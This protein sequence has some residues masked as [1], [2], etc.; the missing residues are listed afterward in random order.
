MFLLRNRIKTSPSS[1]VHEEVKK[2]QLQEHNVENNF[3]ANPWTLFYE[4]KL[5]CHTAGIKLLNI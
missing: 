1:N 3:V 4:L 5:K 2:T